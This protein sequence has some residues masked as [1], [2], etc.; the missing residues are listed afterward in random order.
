MRNVA[1]NGEYEMVTGPVGSYPH[2]MPNMNIHPT[3]SPLALQERDN[4]ISDPKPYSYYPILH[5][6]NSADFL[7]YSEI[8]NSSSLWRNPWRY[9]QTDLLHQSQADQTRIQEPQ[10][11]NNPIRRSFNG[12]PFTKPS[13]VSNP[14]S[15]NPMTPANS[16]SDFGRR[17]SIDK[18]VVSSRDYEQKENE[19]DNIL[20]TVRVRSPA[21]SKGTKN[22]MS[23]T[24]SAA[25][26]ITTASPRKKVLAERNEP[27]RA[28]VSFSDGKSPFSSLNL[29]D[30]TEE[31]D[32]KS[33]IGLNQNKVEAT[34]EMTSANSDHKEAGLGATPISSKA[35]ESDAVL[36]SKVPSTA[37]DSESVSTVTV[38]PECVN[39]HANFK[40]SPSPSCSSCPILAPLDLDPSLPPYDPKKNY[41]SPRPQFLHYKPNPRIELYLNKERGFDSEEG[42]KCLED[43]FSDTENTEETQSEGSHKESEDASSVEVLEEEEEEEEPHDSEANLMT[44]ETVEGKGA[45]KPHFLTRSKSISLL[46]ILVIACL[47]IP[48]TDSPVVGPS[49]VFKDQTFS[50]L[51]DPYEFAKENLMG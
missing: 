45:S 19:K 6:P 5:S 24:I 33:E 12:N 41:L 21:V 10:K 13:I 40:I 49:S 18:G 32:S 27:I 29:S 48:M 7:S 50:K 31:T 34:C 20:K 3:C 36:N 4:L 38:E 51:Y 28:A 2:L 23:P 43:S 9:L 35:S 11:V 26:K 25:S 1:R 37:H 46:L 39:G 15:F 14:R 47:S 16:P 42:G 44:K 22:F 8:T 17:N 30:V